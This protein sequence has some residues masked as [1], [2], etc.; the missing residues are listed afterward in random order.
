MVER[1]DRIGTVG[2]KFRWT[3][4]DAEKKFRHNA[5]RVLTKNKINKAVELFFNLEKVENI[6][7]VMKEVTL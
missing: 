5:I 1:K 3:E 2:S 4:E 6:A 7:E